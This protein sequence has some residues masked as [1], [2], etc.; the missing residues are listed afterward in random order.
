MTGNTEEGS[1]SGQY[2]HH[3]HAGT[4]I[5][6]ELDFSEPTFLPPHPIP[7][8]GPDSKLCAKGNT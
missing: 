6:D 1:T 3:D 5:V 2:Q 7:L 8:R 4:G